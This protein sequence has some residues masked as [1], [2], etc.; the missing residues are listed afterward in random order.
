VLTSW[1]GRALVRMADDPAIAERLVAHRRRALRATVAAG[2]VLWALRPHAL[3]WTLPLLVISCTIA[4]F[5][6]RRRVLGE[7]WTFPQYLMAIVRIYIA[8]AGFWTLLAL[9]PWLARGGQWWVIVALTATLLA[10]HRWY[11]PL[12]LRL[13][14]D[15]R[16][17]RI[18]PPAHSEIAGVV[19]H[20]GVVGVVAPASQQSI[21]TVY[22]LKEE[23]PAARP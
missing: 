5:S 11:T 9:S 8:W 12:L 3:V 20:P 10:W 19:Y 13:L 1:W 23:R 18:L 7:T 15:R 16:L 2:A 17:V 14:G 22:R 4:A 21:V 6:T